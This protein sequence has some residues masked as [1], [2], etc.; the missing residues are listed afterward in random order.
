MSETHL[1]RKAL[2]PHE[3]VG[4]VVPDDLGVALGRPQVLADAEDIDVVR[5][6][7]A[8]Y[9]EQLVLRLPK[10]DHETGLGDH[11]WRRRLDV[12]KEREAVRVNSF[13]PD[14]RVE[15]RNRFGVVVEDVGAGVDHGLHRLQ[16]ALEI[17]GEHLDRRAGAAAAD[18]PDGASEDAG[19]AV[20]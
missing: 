7:V 20:L 9:F 4:L 3:L 2:Q 12:A 18:R 14:P 1:E 17:W 16:V 8:K 13:G 15:T 6:H 19:P 10:A 11:V 5:A